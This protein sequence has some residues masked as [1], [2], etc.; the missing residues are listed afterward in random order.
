MRKTVS[1]NF[2]LLPRTA[3]DSGFVKRNMHNEKDIIVEWAT[4]NFK[5][6]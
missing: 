6:D 5:G 2:F 4:Q 3:L 1:E